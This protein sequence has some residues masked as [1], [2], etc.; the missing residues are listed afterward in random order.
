MSELQEHEQHKINAELGVPLPLALDLLRDSDNHIELA[1]PITGDLN[2]PDLSVSSIIS[3][4][5]LSAIKTAIIYNYSPLGMLSLAS[6]IFNLATALRFDPLE[7]DYRSVTLSV[8]SNQQLDK[9]SKLMQDKSKVKFLICGEATHADWTTQ[10]EGDN[11]QAD[12]EINVDFILDLANQRQKNVIDYLINNHQIDATRLISCQVKIS[13]N[14]N[15]K[16]LV[17]LSI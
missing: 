5:T 1:I 13:Q 2:N 11:K 10:I 12:D 17:K 14:K 9:L 4:V 6:G 3:T 16:A 15:D 8:Q 7:F